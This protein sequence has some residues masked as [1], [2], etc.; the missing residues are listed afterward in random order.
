MK[1]KKFLISILTVT[2][3]FSS[4]IFTSVLGVNATN[5]NKKGLGFEDNLVFYGSESAF[6]SMKTS[7]AIISQE[8]GYV[9]NDKYASCTAYHWNGSSFISTDYCCS[10]HTISYI[11]NTAND[12]FLTVNAYVEKATYYG[13]LHEGSDPNSNY[14]DR[15]WVKRY[16]N[17]QMA[18]H[19]N[20]YTYDFTY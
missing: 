8:Q 1:L 6:L 14:V 12:D 5:V 10:N 3:V 19:D 4:V 7:C 13:E 16:K 18:A 17:S 15:V 20:V 11:A 9:D 2:T